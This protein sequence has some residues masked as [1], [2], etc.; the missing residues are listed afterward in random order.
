MLAQLT[1]AAWEGISKITAAIVPVLLICIT[2]ISTVVVW[3]LK[4]IDNKASAAAAEASKAAVK[5]DRVETTLA[6][7]TKDTDLKLCEIKD[8]SVATHTLVNS[9]YGASLMATLI[10]LRNVERLTVV[11]EDRTAARAAVVEAERLYADHQ[12]K[13]AD[14]DASQGKQ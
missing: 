9:N 14:V 12:A 4:R 8:I 5:A 1:D 2:L 3:L 11:E 13:Q 6:N 7:T 10:A